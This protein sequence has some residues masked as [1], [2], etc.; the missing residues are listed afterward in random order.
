M[1]PEGEKD[2]YI[3]DFQSVAWC[4]VRHTLRLGIKRER[5]CDFVPV[6]VKPFSQRGDTDSELM[7]M[8]TS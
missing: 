3:A 2:I 5:S 7:F 6:A 1:V 8:C 4:R